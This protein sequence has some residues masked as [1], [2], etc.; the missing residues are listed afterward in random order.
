MRKIRNAL[1][2]LVSLA[3]APAEGATLAANLLDLSLEQLSNVVVSTVSGRE[4]PLARAPASVYVITAEDIRRS[5]YVSLPEVLR[6][7]PNL[8]VARADASQ[9]AISARGFNNTAANKMLVLIDGR[10]VYTPLF[11]GTFWEAQDVMLEDVERIEVISGPGATLWG[12]N[13]VNGVINVISRRA[14]GTQ[15]GLGVL[16]SGTTQRDAAA[17]Y[18]GAMAGGHWRAYGKSV[19]RD[20]SSSAAGVPI[21][22]AAEHV[23]G[24]FR[25][26]WGRATEGFTLQGDAYNGEVAGQARAYSG[27]NLLARWNREVGGGQVRVQ[28]YYDRTDRNHMGVFIE[29]LDTWDL[30]VQHALA[31]AG[32]HRVIWG[33]GLRHHRDAVTNFPPTI[34]WQPEGRS[35]KR[36][37]AFVQDEIAL[38]PD[39]DLTLGGKLEA[40]SYTGTE[41]LPS[42]RLG[43]RATP[44]QLFW[45]ALSRAVRAP[46]RIDRELFSPAAGLIGG[47]AF[48]SEVSKVWEVGTRG[49]PTGRLTYSVTLF[50]HQHESLRT[51]APAPGGG[52]TVANGREGRSNGIE[53]W[54]SWRA[55]D[56]ARFSGGFVNQR[57]SLRLRPGAVD[58]GAAGSEGNDPSTFWKLRAAFDIGPRHALDFMLRHYSA[59][60]TPN[61]P[62]YTALDARFAWQATKNVELSLA[63]QNLLDRRHAEWGP[64]ANRAEFERAA[65]LKLRVSGD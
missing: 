51:L 64:A 17:R 55:A 28:G 29:H 35:L 60:P 44:T 19:R 61:V 52:L 26:D 48:E 39:L 2:L 10:T 14:A 27:V 56:W 62:A 3:G 12:A 41:F 6:L 54:A 31:P 43:W 47:T 42:A 11:S 16:Q 32:A 45:T 57:K 53:A 18:G 33:F 1:A 4:E 65:F 46:S 59:L 7:A 5:G 63:V 20:N 38:R 21:R 22:D 40:N 36:N 58:L 23:Q 24:G 9:Y 50:H 8:A 37:H 30:D 13:A 34:V 15:G 25:A 49:Q